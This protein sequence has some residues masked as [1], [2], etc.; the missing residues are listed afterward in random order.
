MNL[1]AIALLAN[2]G[3]LATAIQQRDLPAGCNC[4]GVVGCQYGPI[5]DPPQGTLTMFAPNGTDMGNT[6]GP[7]FTVSIQWR[8]GTMEHT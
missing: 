6:G 5:S 7:G 8:R 1:L 3:S 2:L 4:T